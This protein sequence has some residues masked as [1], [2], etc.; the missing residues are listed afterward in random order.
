MKQVVRK[1][2]IITQMILG[3]HVQHFHSSGT[4]SFEI[5]KHAA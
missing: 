2:S 5:A 3:A 4:L 1:K